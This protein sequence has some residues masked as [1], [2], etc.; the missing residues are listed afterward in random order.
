MN[1]KCWKYHEKK[2]AKGLNVLKIAE[3]GDL[4]HNKYNDMNKLSNKINEN[5]QHF[6]ACKKTND[7]NKSLL[8]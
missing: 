7:A 5:M 2:I 4:V 1:K 3:S 6:N 8:N